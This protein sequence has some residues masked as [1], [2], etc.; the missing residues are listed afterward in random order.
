MKT[1]LTVAVAAVAA[2]AIAAEML[3]AHYWGEND[4]VAPQPVELKLIASGESVRLS[5]R[6]GPLEELGVTLTRKDFANLVSKAADYI[7]YGPGSVQPLGCADDAQGQ[8]F[9]VM[10]D[11]KPPTNT[12]QVTFKF[13]DKFAKTRW[14]YLKPEELRALAASLEQ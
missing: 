14:F 3:T 1:L 2:P 8:S 10:G 9:C 6:D 11:R 7:D 12:P 4:Y 13:K 5:T